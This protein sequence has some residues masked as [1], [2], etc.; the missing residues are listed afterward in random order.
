MHHFG[1][2]RWQKWNIAMR[3]VL[4]QSQQKRG[5]ESGSWDPKGPHG[6]QGGRLYCTALAVCTLEVYYRHAP[7]FRQLETE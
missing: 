5:H 7:I 3:D 6:S 1:G 2:K 4:V